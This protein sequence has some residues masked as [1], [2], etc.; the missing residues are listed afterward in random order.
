MRAAKF[1][2]EI[3]TRRSYRAIDMDVTKKPRNIPTGTGGLLRVAGLLVVIFLL[4]NIILEMLWVIAES[5]ETGESI[6]TLLPAMLSDMPTLLW[7]SLVPMLGIIAWLLFVLLLEITAHEL[8]HVI[9]ARAVGFRFVLLI[10]G[11][12]RISRE[13]DRV[14][15]G[16]REA[17][18]PQFGAAL[19]V[20]VDSHN[21]RIRTAISVAGGPAASLA[22]GL[23]S[24]MLALL[25]FRTGWAGDILRL[26]AGLSLLSGFFN[27]LPI[28][29]GGILSDGARIKMLLSGGPASERYCLIS[30]LSGAART[31]QRP[32]EWDET[33]VRRIG[34]LGDGS[35][36]D[37]AASHI[38]FYWLL[39]RGDVDGAE[40]TLEKL[41]AAA[42]AV[43]QVLHPV[44]NAE[45][46]FFY[47]YYRRDL[48][49]ACSFLQKVGDRNVGSHYHMQARAAAAVLALEGQIEAARK[50]AAS[51]LAHMER[52]QKR[53]PGWELDYEWLQA[54]AT[55]SPAA[56]AP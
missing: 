45:A 36:D 27:M 55:I 47:A 2:T 30:A 3:R 11:P 22:L 37:A 16:L 19:S 44:L 49:K 10:I 6:I 29:S 1:S 52:E 33:W 54:L 25:F 38:T 4:T 28:K 23:T 14:K 35:L 31:G 39:D 21:L 20:P 50:K 18:D 13:G 17:W 26:S 34:E 24:T 56:Q 7:M 15:V 51:G 46:A 12:L 41:L 43:P 48:Q 53:G 8:G 32:R 40:R 9:A 5:R 42:K